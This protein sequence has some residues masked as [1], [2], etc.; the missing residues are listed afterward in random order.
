MPSL[1]ALDD[2][3]VRPSRAWNLNISQADHSLGL[4]APDNHHLPGMKHSR[5]ISI[6]NC[7]A[8]GEVG[9]V[10]VGGIMDVP[11]AKTINGICVST[12]LLEC[13]MLEMKEPVTK[14]K[15][16]TAAG[17]VDVAAKCS[18]GKCKSV[19]FEN[20]PSFVDTMGLEVDALGIPRKVKVDI[21][22]GSMWFA[23]VDAASVGVPLEKDNAMELVEMGEKIKK[24]VKRTYTPV[25]PENHGLKGVSIISL[26]GPLREEDLEGGGRCKTA[27]NA[28]VVGPGRLDRCPTGT[29][30][31]A[32]MALLHAKEQLR[33]GETF[34]HQTVLGTEFVCRIQKDG[35]AVGRKDAVI[36]YVEGRA[37]IYG[38][39]LVL[40]DPEDPFQTGYRVGDQ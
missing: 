10:V 2:V 34:T 12:V 24:A 5:M 31:S 8:E 39:Q 38:H 6:I 3:N 1:G 7:H 18:G 14:F 4:H 32:R 33:K 20:I 17:V 13:G 25:H 37:W 29:G 26:T 28:V 21:A 16:D 19:G 22:W 23:I 30:T 35:V 15:L 9:D 27:T 36:S 40:L 11:S